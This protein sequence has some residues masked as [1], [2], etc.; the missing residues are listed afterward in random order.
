M[1]KKGSLVYIFISFMLFITMVA[2]L[3]V[4]KGSLAESFT[5]FTGKI[6][7]KSF[8]DILPIIAFIAIIKEAFFFFLPVNVFTFVKVTEE[9]RAVQLS[10]SRFFIC[11][12]SAHGILMLVVVEI[13]S[14]AAGRG[15][16]NYSIMWVAV[17][18]CF[19]ILVSGLVFWNIL[20]RK[21]R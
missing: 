7:K 12:L 18:G 9:N 13:F 21:N 11:F 15:N 6:I 16:E 1:Y 17:A 4:S 3:M 20:A 19:I 10:L 8:L 14:I 2:L 5:W